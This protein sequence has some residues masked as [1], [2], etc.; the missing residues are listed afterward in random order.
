[1]RARSLCPTLPAL[2]LLG[3]LLGTAVA[4]PA[5]A[6]ADRPQAVPAQDLEARKLHSPSG[7][8]LGSIEDIVID[9]TTGRIV[10]AVVELGGFLGIG[11]RYFP[12]PWP[13][14][15]ASPDG[16]DLVLDIA[17]D[18]MRGAPQFTRSNR[19]DMTDP[20]WATAVHAYYG[21]PPYWASAGSGNGVY[22]DVTTLRQEVQRLSGEVDRLHQALGETQPSPQPSAA[23][24]GDS[25]PAMEQGSGATLST[26]SQPAPPQPAP[27]QP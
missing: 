8:A 19:P 3:T 12:V 25:A 26:P 11:E 2:A 22:G 16:Q 7:E 27:P 13:L 4:L 18:R 5:A 20:Q 17:A 15:K 9:P 6:A 21:V 1:M 14:V 10:Y 23:T 24:S